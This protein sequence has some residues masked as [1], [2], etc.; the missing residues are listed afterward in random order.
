MFGASVAENIALR[1]P[2]R[3]ATPRSRPRPSAPPRT[4][5]SPRC[6]RATTRARRARRHAVGRPA[7]APRHRARDPQGRA[8]PAARRGDLGARRRERDAGAGG[9]RQADAGPHDA[10]DRPPARHDRQR[11]P[12]PRPR[13]R[14]DRRAGRPTRPCSPK[15]G[16]TRGSPGCNS[17][18]APRPC[19]PSRR[20]NR[21]PDMTARALMF[22][23]TGSDV[24]KSLIVAGLCRA[25]TRRG[26]ACAPFKPQNMSNNAAVTADG[27]EIGRAQALQA[28]ACR[29]RAERPHEP[30]AAE[31]AERDRRAGGRAGPRSSAP[32]RRASTRRW[33]PKLLPRVL[34]SFARL[35][36]ARPTSCWSRAPAARRRSICAPATS[37]TWASRARPDVPSCWSA[38]STAAASSRRSSAPT[39]CSTPTTPR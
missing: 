11:R 39:P 24:G 13:R 7:P 22:Q 8:D 30:G 15:A 19:R 10:G 38:T 27:G 28:R 32:P 3:L 6:R 16:S 12:H 17:R 2:R 14:R 37:P 31:A 29:R 9:A 35:Q 36:R 25:L 26:L 1:P 18:P 34:E 5:S 20:R 23:G 21:P 33:K 4:A